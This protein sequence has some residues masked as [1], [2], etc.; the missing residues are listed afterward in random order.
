[1]WWP[2][3]ER[4]NLRKTFEL[5]NRVGLQIGLNAHNWFNHANYGAPTSETI[6]GASS[7]GKVILCKRRRP[8]LTERSRLRQPT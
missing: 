5:T 6:L 2:L 1:M 8:L 4:W 3:N 7:F